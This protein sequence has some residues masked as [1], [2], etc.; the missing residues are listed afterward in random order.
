MKIQTAE[1]KKEIVD[2][3]Q[4]DGEEHEDYLRDFLG[5][6]LCTT[7]Q[8][9]LIV[10]TIIR[11]EIVRVGDWIVKDSDGEIYVYDEEEFK[12]KFNLL[13]G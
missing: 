6:R 3:I 1:R 2:A 7:N 13:H 12:E 10:R 4:W 9:L 8:K 11:I 5:K